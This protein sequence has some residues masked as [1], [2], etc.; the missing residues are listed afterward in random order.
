M[1]ILMISHGHPRYSK[2]GAEIAAM[3]L[4]K[5]LRTGKNEVLFLGRSPGGKLQHTGTIFSGIAPNE[6]LVESTGE[7]FLQNQGNFGKEQIDE[8]VAFVQAFKPDVVHFHHYVHLGVELLR[9]TKAACPDAKIVLTLH[10]YIAL[11]AHNGQMIKTGPGGALCYKSDPK[12]CHRCY[13]NQSPEDFFLRERYI[14]Q[15][16]SVVDLFISPSEFLRQRYI[17][18]GLAKDRIIFIENGQVPAKRIPGRTL[19]PEE[20]R[21]RFAY[22]GQINPYKGVD[23]VLEAFDMLPKEIKKLVAMDIYGGGLENQ[24]ED[25][26]AKVNKLLKENKRRVHSH[27]AYEPEDMPRLMGEADWV[28]MGSIWWENSPLVIQ[29]AYKYGRPVICPD[30]GGMAEKVKDGVTGLHFRARDPASL[31]L[32]MEKCVRESALWDSLCANLPV[33]MT[34]A[35]SAKAHVQAYDRR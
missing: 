8:W 4:A 20:G 35:E 23:V 13:P 24:T 5:A 7:W 2:G 18:W 6:M 26:Q 30:I 16:F 22:F 25:F 21:T 15:M 17:D 27:G 9:V 33:P 28:V 11:C 29:E 34:V 31:A 10:E 3:D 19:A 32:A 14:K 12:D 1:R